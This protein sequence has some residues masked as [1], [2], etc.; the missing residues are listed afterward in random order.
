MSK[1]PERENGTYGANSVNGTPG[2]YDAHGELRPAAVPEASPS[3][4]HPQAEPSP[5]YDA[6]ADPAAAHGWQNAYDETTE[7]PPV[8]EGADGV[9]AGRGADGAS[10]AGGGYEH[11]YEDR[12]GHAREDRYDYVYEDGYDYGDDY[13]D[14]YD[15]GRGGRRS[16]RGRHQPGVWRSRRVAVAAGLVGAVSLGALVAGFSLSGSSS[17]GGAKTKDDRTSMTTG[18]A[19]V[20]GVPSAGSSAGVLRSGSED[21]DPSGTTSPSASASPSAS[22]DAD[23]DSD[24][25]PSA[26]PTP[27][28]TASSAPTTSTAPGNSDTKPGRGQGN[29][30]KPD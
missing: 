9:H 29:T 11:V 2:A 20:P 27:T 21:T 6:Y 30:K 8:G 26:D 4:Y 13:G 28:G 23:A 24:G 16:H 19:P 18:D 15:A 14:D 25:K 10:G 17:P 12:Y 3:V 7:L 5:V 1:P 22:D